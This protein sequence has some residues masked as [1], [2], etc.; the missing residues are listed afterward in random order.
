MPLQTLI[1]S[2]LPVLLVLVGLALICYGL[3]LI[4]PPLGFIAA[5][6]SCLAVEMWREGQKGT[7]DR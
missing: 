6:L 5:G 7:S 1:G 3:A 4:W 2:V